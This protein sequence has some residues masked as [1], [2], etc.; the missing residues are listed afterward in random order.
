MDTSSDINYGL[1]L[2]SNLSGLM[3]LA[4]KFERGVLAPIHDF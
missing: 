4:S 2:T 3:A 1:G